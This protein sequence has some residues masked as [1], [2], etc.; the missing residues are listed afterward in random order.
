MEWILIHSCYLMLVSYCKRIFGR[1]ENM[2]IFKLVCLKIL[3]LIK[4]EFVKPGAIVIDV[5]INRIMVNGKPK[6]VGDVDPEV[7]NVAGYM[8]PVPGGVGPCTVACLLY[9]TVIAAKRQSTL[10]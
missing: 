6:I 1:Y 5:G 3:G 8:T 4:P 9:N 7:A 2:D 10:V